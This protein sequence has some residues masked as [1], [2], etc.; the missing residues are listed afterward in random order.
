MIVLSFD[1]GETTG[2]AKVNSETGEME[3]G[4]FPKWSWI[5]KL[6][7]TYPDHVVIEEF[8]LYPARA[9]EQSWSSFPS[10]EVIGVIKFIS[11]KANI[12]VTEQSASMAKALVV[13]VDKASMSRH[14]YDALRHA[15]IFLKRRSEDGA[16]RHLIS[17][18]TRTHIPTPEVGT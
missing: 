17:F 2:W 14:A 5:E 1:P 3:S 4:E 15:L 8:K 10:V 16:F 6:I 13:A 18:Q 9:A 7:Y 12:P 11:S